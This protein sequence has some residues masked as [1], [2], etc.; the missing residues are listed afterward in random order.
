MPR[1]TVPIVPVNA[2]TC[3]RGIIY[4]GSKRGLKTFKGYVWGRVAIRSPVRPG[5]YGF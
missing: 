5:Q 2:Q 3:S 1:V 4:L